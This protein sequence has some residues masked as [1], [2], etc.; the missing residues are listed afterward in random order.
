MAFVLGM[1]KETR[2][3][4]TRDPTDHAL[5]EGHTQSNGT[6][7]SAMLQPQAR[8]EGREDRVDG[9]RVTKVRCGQLGR[10]APIHTWPQEPSSVTDDAAQPPW[11][12]SWGT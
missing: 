8:E 1:H 11:R 7:C 2:T 10:T 9:T 4:A 3:A 5:E 6:R 12:V